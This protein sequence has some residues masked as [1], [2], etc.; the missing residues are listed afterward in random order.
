MLFANVPSIAASWRACGMA[1]RNMAD[2]PDDT[3][4]LYC[5]HVNAIDHSNSTSNLK[6]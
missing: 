3:A 6:C 2:A 4:Q 1:P 5:K